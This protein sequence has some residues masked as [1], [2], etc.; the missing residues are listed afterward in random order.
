MEGEGKG[1][2]AFILSKGLGWTKNQSLGELN[3]GGMV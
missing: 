3:K 2:G 1:I